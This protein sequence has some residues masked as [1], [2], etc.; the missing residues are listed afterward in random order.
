M[1]KPLLPLAALIAVV[2]IVSLALHFSGVPEKITSVLVGGILG[3]YA[4]LATTLAEQKKTKQERI[5]EVIKGNTYIH[6]VLVALYVLCYLQFTERTLGAIF[7]TAIAAAITMA[8]ENGQSEE[9]LRLII[10]NVI[11]VI[12]PLSVSVLMILA[13]IPIAKYATHRIKRFPLLWII[14]VII[15]DRAISLAVVALIFKRTITMDS[16]LSQLDL[17]LYLPGAIIGYLWSRKTHSVYLMTHLFKQLSQS[18]QKSLIELAQTLPGV[19]TAS[20]S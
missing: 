18:D 4:T 15:L 6:P 8:L 19:A 12:G 13:I 9:Q 7:G 17:P 14:G 1:N 16:I 10:S 11:S 3:L 20:K 5:A 2:L